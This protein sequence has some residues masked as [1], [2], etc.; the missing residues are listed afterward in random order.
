MELTTGGGAHG[1]G[2][3]VG[4]CAARRRRCL[5][6]TASSR[7]EDAEVELGRA[8]AVDAGVAN[9]VM[10]PAHLVLEL[11]LE[12]PAE[13]GGRISSSSPATTDDSRCCS[14]RREREWEGEASSE[15]PLPCSL[16]RA[17]SA[18]ASAE[19]L[20][21]GLRRAAAR[22]SRRGGPGGRGAGEGGKSRG[23][24]RCTQRLPGPRPSP[25]AAQPGGCDRASLAVP[26]SSAC[27]ACEGPRPSPP[28]A[29]LGGRD[30]APPGAGEEPW[31][32]RRKGMEEKPACVPPRSLAQSVPLRLRLRRSPPSCTHRC[33]AAPAAVR[34]ASAH[35]RGRG[36]WRSEHGAELPVV[37]CNGEEAWEAGAPSTGK[38]AV[39]PFLSHCRIRQLA[40]EET[41]DAAAGTTP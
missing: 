24:S 37:P 34:R 7:G 13:L 18:H 33:L 9:D 23:R 39:T 2:G 27:T 6:A 21:V 10:D 35:G 31:A 29:P 32:R 1:A 5:I 15:P 4:G 36:A 12:E 17:A 11:W 14:R 22:R 28:A 38:P 19:Q 40:E 41:G 26:P 8:G 25:P 3:P 16:H 30:R 20:C